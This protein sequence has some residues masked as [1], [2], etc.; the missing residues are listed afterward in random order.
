MDDADALY[1]GLI[2][3]TS[4]D[5]IDAVL[6]DFAQGRPRL[7]ASH[8]EPW[9]E[10][11]RRRLL[12]VAQ[13]GAALDLD[14]FGWLDVEAGE[15]FAAAVLHLLQASG[16]SPD[17]VRA[18][19]S[20]GQT[21]RHRPG[22]AHPFSLQVGDPTIIAER[23]GIEV[24]ADFR[25][26][27]LAAGGQGAPLVPALHAMLFADPPRTSVVLN[28][29]GIANISVLRGDGEV[30]GFDTGPASCLLDAWCVAQR[31]EPFDRDG[32]FAASGQLDDTLLAELLADPYF[33]AAAPKST[34]REYFHLDW[35][36]THPRASR[37][38]AADMQATLL[39][40]TACSVA[41][42][43]QRHAARADRVLVCGGGVHN[44]ALMRRLRT[45]LQPA[46]VDSTASA[47]LDPDYVEAVAF[48][49]LARQRLLDLPGNVP[50][51]TGARGPRVL[52]AVYAAPRL[53]LIQ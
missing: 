37:V 1:V 47:G 45:L 46:A 21:L 18:I 14:A 34:G 11:L 25:R 16:T 4:A 38:N 15:G 42:A 32:A 41:Q 20:H 12:A 52:G 51:V 19:G 29:G 24:V 5:G 28:L 27:D 23:C 33:A 2:S 13:P 43:I 17:A 26:A 53:A 3:G 10:A 44:G 36:R 49:W 40:L 8:V 50:A 48:A 30:L 22:G 35:L 31:G 6:V 9:P 39:E 7:H